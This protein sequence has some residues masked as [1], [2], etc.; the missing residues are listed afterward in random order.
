MSPNARQIPL[1]AVWLILVAPGHRPGR[2]GGVMARR[3][4]LQG[5]DDHL[6]DLGVGDRAGPARPW[7]IG[8]ALQPLAHEPASPLGHRLGPDPQP[9]GHS[10]MGR[11]LGTDQHDPRPQDHRLGAGATPR[12][13]LQRLPLLPG[14][15]PRRFG[16]A[17]LCYARR[18]P[19]T[20]RTNASGH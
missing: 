5:L 17:T 7:L 6:L 15:G 4:L 8:Q 19:F 9:L 10:D 18:L 1:I 13:T 11:A 20:Q 16:S 2:P 12:P 3:R 14:Q